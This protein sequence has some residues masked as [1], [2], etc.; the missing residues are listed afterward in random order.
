MPGIVPIE[1]TI[2]NGDLG[3]TG[4]TYNS[5]PIINDVIQLT[6]R[7]CTQKPWNGASALAK[8]SNGELEK[9]ALLD[10]KVPSVLHLKSVKK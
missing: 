3:R 8:W 2:L 1:V 6:K 7:R 10:H 4:T 5:T 9:R